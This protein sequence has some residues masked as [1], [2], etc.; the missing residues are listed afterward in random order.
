MIPLFVLVASLPQQGEAPPGTGILAAIRDA[1]VRYTGDGGWMTWTQ[2]FVLV[3][4]A[5]LLDFAQRKILTHLKKGLER[6]RT[7]WDDAILDSLTAPISLLIWVPGISLAAT[8]VDLEIRV[9]Y[10][11]I[12]LTLVVSL[13]WFLLR[14]IRNGQANLLEASRPFSSPCSSSA[15]TSPPSWLSGASAASPWDSQPKIYWPTSS[16]A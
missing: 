7:P 6:T 16:A 11:I 15:S 1:I 3:F 10:K 9:F 14:L 5:L 4:S 2:V 12:S 8:F 13:T